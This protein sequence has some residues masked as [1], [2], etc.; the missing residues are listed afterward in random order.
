MGRA[1]SCRHQWAAH[2]GEPLVVC[3]E[4][5]WDHIR[6]MYRE[7]RQ[8]MDKDASRSHCPTLLVYPGCH[9]RVIAQ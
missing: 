6:E 9:K 4:E 7:D 3:D 8:E 5:A 2:P 1:A